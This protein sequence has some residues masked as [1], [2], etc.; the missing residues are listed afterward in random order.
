MN[1]VDWFNFAVRIYAGCGRFPTKPLD[2]T[3]LVFI[4]WA[5]QD[6]IEICEVNVLV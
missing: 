1:I 3:N 5:T 4:I 6:P 2:S